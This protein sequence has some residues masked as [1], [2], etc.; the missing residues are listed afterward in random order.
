MTFPYT[1]LEGEGLF[2]TE[3]LSSKLGGVCKPWEELAHVATAGCL[4]E[5]LNTLGRS[6]LGFI[7]RTEHNAPF[8]DPTLGNHLG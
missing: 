4:L 1:Q 2:D 8:V 5:W 7:V 3:T 6:P